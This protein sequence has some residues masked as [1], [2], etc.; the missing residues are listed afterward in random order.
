MVR[1]NF[2]IV[3]LLMIGLVSA[4]TLLTNGDFEQDFSV[5]WQNS[6]PGYYD[7]LVRGSTYQPDPDMEAYVF[8]AYGGYFKLFQ[9]V[10]IPSTD[11]QF[12]IDASMS[13]YDNNADTLC[14]AAA[15]VIVSYLN[16]SNAVLGQTRICR[17]TTP[18]PWTS[19]STLHLIPAADESWHT[20]SFSVVSELGNLPGVNP[21]LIKKV[22]VALY[23]TAAHTC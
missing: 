3:M 1:K 18:C 8:H 22:E 6:A 12:S 16:A 10:D 13:A 23:D 17:Y 4:S 7:S 11:L 15:S 2:I 14:W 5:G 19:T 9:T 21:L 20:Y